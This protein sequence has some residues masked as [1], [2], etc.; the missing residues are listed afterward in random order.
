MLLAALPEKLRLPLVLS[1]CEGMSYAEIATALRL[2]MA[3]VRGRIHRA[4]IELRKEL[5][6]SPV[7]E[8][9]CLQS[10]RAACRAGERRDGPR[11]EL[12]AE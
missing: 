7:R 1:L 2:P 3:T 12:E 11:K 9:D 6:E 10:P 8:S 4:K 5:D